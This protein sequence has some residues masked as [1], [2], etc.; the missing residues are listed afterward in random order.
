MMK[1][2]GFSSL[3][4]LSLLICS[5]GSAPKSRA[6]AD[7]ID[8]TIEP[9]PG[10][11]DPSWITSIP[12]GGTELFFVGAS[13]RYGIDVDTATAREKA[14]QNARRGVT[15]YYG[16][17]I[18]AGVSEKVS[19]RESTDNIASYIEIESISTS[20]AQSV[21]SEISFDDYYTKKYQD[22]NGRQYYE[23]YVLCHISR[24]K[25]EDDIRNFEKNTS[26]RYSGLMGNQ[27]TLYAALGA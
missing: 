3:I 23:V 4:T 1:W 11:I 2:Y 5:C 14:E 20:S 18:Q 16:E 26:E 15:R 25:A 22:K 10:Q 13:G 24:Q 21:I 19:Y 7:R 8:Q 12:T 17:Y 6:A 9:V 27:N